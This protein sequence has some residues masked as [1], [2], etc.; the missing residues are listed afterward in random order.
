MKHRTV[1]PEDET[2][3]HID[4]GEV[5]KKTDEG[6]FLPQAGNGLILAENLVGG[7][8]DGCVGQW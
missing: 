6:K 8:A 7:Q 2:D 5:C 1:S 3:Q 4:V